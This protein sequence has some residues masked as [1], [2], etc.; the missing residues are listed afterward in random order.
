M[1]SQNYPEHRLIFRPPLSY[2]DMGKVVYNARYLDIYNYA[3]DEYMRSIGYS[4]IRLN[5][6]DNKNL[7]VV[8]ANIKYRKPL[9]YDEETVIVSKVEKIGF[10]SILFDQKIYKDT[11]NLLC[12]ESKF[13]MVCID[14]TFKTS[15]IPQAL[16][17]AFTNGPINF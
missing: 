2:I 5:Q 13:I 3:R 10:R 17:Q 15:S 6:E 14:S 7:A 8:E 1:A 4:Y 16:K 9:Y 11:M 12:N